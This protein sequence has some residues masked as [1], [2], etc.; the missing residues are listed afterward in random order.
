MNPLIIPRKAGSKLNHRRLLR[1]YQCTICKVPTNS[2]ELVDRDKLQMKTIFKFTWGLAMA[3]QIFAQGPAKPPPP[4]PT[5][6]KAGLAN[7]LKLNAYADNW[8]IVYI[9]GKMAAVDQ[10]EF[11][12]HNVVS[13]TVLPIY[14]M[15]IAVMAKDNADP[16][17]GLEYGTQIGDGGFILKLSDGTVTSAAWKAKNFFKGPLNSNTVNPQVLHTPI[18]ANWFAPDFDDS[19]WGYATE[20]T[21]DQVKPDGDYGSYDFSGA[22]F[23]WTEDLLLD[24][25]IVFR[26]TAQAPP[27][28]KKAWNA[29]GDFAITDIVN[30]AKLAIPSAPSLFQVNSDGLATGYLT[31]VRGAQQITEQFA[32]TIAGVTSAIPIDLGASTDQVYLVL[33]G[34]NLGTVTT[35][36]ATIGGVAA[37]VAYAGNLSPSNGVAQ[38]NI[39][40]PRSLAGKG[41]AE[42]IVT[43]NGKASNAVTVNIK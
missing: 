40:I 33:Y 41:A 24:N 29:D 11:L 1:G 17:T 27:N 31:R 12:P 2:G 25:T 5:I 37:P 6:I 18:P 13:V 20:F 34:G 7:I 39:A 30:E 23:I 15:T 21:S 28:Y 32:Q 14:P 9:N 8:C 43:V 4:D 10:I 16:N 19:S 42:L 35:A 22:K 38:F 3:T 36:T 26:Y